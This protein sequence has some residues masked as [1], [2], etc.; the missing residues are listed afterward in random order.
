[1]EEYADALE[2]WANCF[3]DGTLYDAYANEIAYLLE[4]KA[5]D[6]RKDLENEQTS[7]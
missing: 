6:I 2:H 3:R 7:T 5:Y 4:D 1:M